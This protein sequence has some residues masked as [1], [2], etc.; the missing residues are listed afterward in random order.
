MLWKWPRVQSAC[1]LFKSFLFHRLQLSGNYVLSKGVIC[2]L[3]FERIK[4]F[5]CICQDSNNTWNLWFEDFNL[6]DNL[7]CNLHLWMKHQCVDISRNGCNLGMNFTTTAPR[8]D[9]YFY[10]KRKPRISL[11]DM[12]ARKGFPRFS[13]VL[14]KIE[15]MQIENPVTQDNCSALFGK[16][17]GAEQLPSW[18]NFQSAAHS[19]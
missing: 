10:P 14:T 8:L 15:N 9:K 16:P 5:A 13:P 18:Q 4:I 7:D 19:H 1:L 11:P 3:Y 12:Y 2:T 17:R 6:T